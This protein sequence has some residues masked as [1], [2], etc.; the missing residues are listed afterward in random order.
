MFEHTKTI[1][2]AAHSL[3]AGRPYT[4]S[5]NVLEFHDEK[6]AEGNNL[7]IVDMTELEAEVV[8]L[9]AEYDA[10]QY[11]RDR[12]AEYPPMADYL[13]AVVKGDTVAQQSY[14]DACQAVKDKYPKVV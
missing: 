12:V 2:D 5:D 8:R 11:Q 1:A 3:Y 9:Q 14:I 13:D 6:D 7:R 10:L 4:I